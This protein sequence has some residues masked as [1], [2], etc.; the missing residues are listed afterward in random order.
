MTITYSKNLHIP[1]LCNKASFSW[2]YNNIFRGS[3]I[4][5][6]AEP[7]TGRLG[8]DSRQEQECFSRHPFQTGSGAY[9]PYQMGTWDYI[10]RV[11]TAGAWSWKLAQLRDY[12]HVELYLLSPYVFMAWCLINHRDN[13]TSTLLPQITVES[14]MYL[15]ANLKF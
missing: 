2:T 8:F 9:P 1:L 11:K 13:S 10:S 5:I 12:D 7:R 15:S 6:M 3:S 4:G 14:T